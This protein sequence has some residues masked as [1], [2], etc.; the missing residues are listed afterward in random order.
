MDFVINFIQQIVKLIS[1]QRS[2]SLD[3]GEDEVEDAYKWLLSKM[4]D[5]RQTEVENHRGPY[6]EA[7][8]MYVFKY[9][10]KYK[11]R[12]AYYDKHPIVLMLGK[13][14]AAEGMMNVGI[15]ISWY[16]PKARKYIVETI[17]KLYAPLYESSIKSSPKQAKKQ[18]PVT[19]DLVAL[20]TALDQ[21]GLSFAIRSYLPS[22]IKS[23]AVCICYENWDKAIKLD[24]PKIFPEVQGGIALMQI[25]KEY[26][27]YVKYCQKNIGTIR[28][29][30]NEAK[31][32]NRYK[33]IK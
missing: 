12:Y 24:Q 32:Q 2:A 26:E 3:E 6:L 33:F 17:R 16:P 13:M 31:K 7:G 19:L 21:Y 11:E 9:D 18:K 28:K 5:G 4:K 1:A 23:P 29:K 14:P 20:K 22:Q 30:M 25:Y 15:N 10:P 8:K 27:L